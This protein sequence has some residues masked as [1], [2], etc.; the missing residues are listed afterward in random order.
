MTQVSRRKFFGV[1]AGGAAALV[2][3]PIA[4]GALSQDVFNSFDTYQ[5]IGSSEDLS[6]L[7]Y[8]IKPTDTPRR[9]CIEIL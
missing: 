8:N 3:C 1:L 7:I 9:W 4:A 2:V 6:D 5:S